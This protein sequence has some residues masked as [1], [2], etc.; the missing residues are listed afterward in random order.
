MSRCAEI[1]NANSYREISLR[2]VRELASDQNFAHFIGLIDPPMPGVELFLIVP[3]FRH[4]PPRTAKNKQCR[5][6]GINF[7]GMGWTMISIPVEHTDIAR[8]VAAECG[9][10]IDSV[11][12]AMETAGKENFLFPVWGQTVYELFFIP[13]HH[14]DLSF[15]EDFDEILRKEQER[16]EKIL[17]V[18]SGADMAYR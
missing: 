18:A 9:V 10:T 14:P 6:I 7:S 16:I 4:F 5:I 17:F 1:I 13:N 12:E 11:T 8:R 15:P 3:E 2:A